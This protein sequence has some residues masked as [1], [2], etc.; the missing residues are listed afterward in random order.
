[1]TVNGISF[2]W[3]TIAAG[4]N[5]NW[6]AAGQVIPVSNGNGATTLAFLG[7]ATNGPSSGTITVTYTDGTTQTFTIAFSDWTLNG[8]SA[9]ILPGDSV[10]AKMTYR[11]SSSGQQSRTTY[12]FSTS[13]SLTSGK[14]VQSVTL[15][16][17]VSQGAIHVL[18]VGAGS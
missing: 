2:Q 4:S 17:S 9:S 13:V 11:N 10:A 14:T 1:M 5:D 15:P 8:G 16:G 3:P 7:S 6:Q 12:L 18:A